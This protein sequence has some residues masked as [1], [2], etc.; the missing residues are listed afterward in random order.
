MS[1]LDKIK[2]DNALQS[3]AQVS[4]LSESEVAKIMTADERVRL[5]ETGRDVDA[6]LPM[7][8]QRPG[9]ARSLFSSALTG[10]APSRTPIV[11]G[12]IVEQSDGGAILRISGDDTDDITGY[13]DVARR[14][15]F[16]VQAGRTYQVSARFR[17]NVD[18]ANP[19]NNAVEVR[20]QNLAFDKSQINNVVLSG[21]LTPVFANGVWVVAYRIG[22]AG[23]ADNQH[24]TIPEAAR[25]GVPHLRIY[26]NGQELDVIDIDVTDI[27]DI[28]DAENE[29]AAQ[30]VN[31]RWTSTYDF[32]GSISAGARAFYVSREL[33][34][35]RGRFVLNGTYGTASTEIPTHHKLMLG[36]AMSQIY[37][38]LSDTTNPFRVA[39]FPALAPV[40]L[41][42]LHLYNVRSGAVS[43]VAGGEVRYASVTLEGKLTFRNAIVMTKNAAGTPVAMI[44]RCAYYDRQ[45]DFMS[46]DPVVLNNGQYYWEVPIIAASTQ[47]AR[48]YFDVVAAIAGQMPWKVAVASAVP[49][50]PRDHLLIEVLTYFNGVVKSPHMLAGE[51]P[52]GA[53]E[54]QFARGNDP[55]RAQIFS[56]NTTTVNVTDP[57]LTAMGLTRGWS[58]TDAFMGEE[59]PDGL[60]L[61][62]W[63]FGRV[64]VQASVDEGWQAPILYLLDRHDD[65]IGT[66][67]MVMEKRYSARV[68]SFVCFG[69][70]N[71][72]R[73]PKK[74]NIGTFQSTNQAIICGGQFYVGRSVNSV[75]PAM[76]YP[77][78]R[79]LTPIYGPQ[80]FFA[81]D[82]PKPV[83]L[84]NLFADRQRPAP[85][86]SFA[87]RKGLP[88]RPLDEQAS[89]G[90]IILDPA[91]IGTSVVLR[92][93]SEEERARY[94][95]RSVSAKV[96]SAALVG[97]SVSAMFFGDSISH[98]Q[99]PEFVRQILATYGITMT[100]LGTIE[101]ADTLFTTSAGGPKCE[102]REGW[103]T[104]D[105]LGTDLSDGDAANGVLPIGQ[106]TAYLAMSKEERR[107]YQVYLNPDI[108][109]GS[110]APIVT[111]GGVQY[112]FDFRFFLNRFGIADP[113]F[114][115]FNY[116]MNNLIE[117][118]T[119][120]LG[121]YKVDL[122]IMLAE[123]RRALPDTHII[124]WSTTIPYDLRVEDNYRQAWALMH[125]FLVEQ[126]VA[127]R[128]AGDTKMHLVSAWAHQ[129]NIAG[130]PLQAIATDAAGVDRCILSDPVHPNGEARDQ[131]SE[132]L[133]LAIACIKAGI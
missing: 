84:D 74:A 44:P 101:S 24:A 27:T 96:L 110:Q 104:T 103:A 102:A 20:W 116:G 15:D 82:R 41:R 3:G 6:L 75:I 42:Y 111:I 105:A 39:D 79:D 83:Y 123:L 35:K 127:L 87:S 97:A 128:A 54:S 66:A 52:G 26:G 17:R 130:W 22:K 62:G 12:T 10:S 106:E 114:L 98:R 1:H 77:G 9:D 36:S 56:I 65:T 46:F 63:Y 7:A 72:S 119:T 23:A 100:G 55:D 80:M 47:E 112:R 13:I 120:A 88:V 70:Y 51:V 99:T 14:I 117:G 95:N 60:P 11:A 71:Y 45:R 85:M 73:R 30:T 124:N 109:A 94:D 126:V 115:P 61:S 90:K 37:L 25:Y 93:I 8:P 91:R 81:W 49:T 31:L 19:A 92:R 43:R 16:P 133:A 48:V 33:Y 107:K 32:D 59:L 122:P 129:S 121:I 76:Q 113:E 50:F 86:V 18:A 68:A 108:N 5:E 53:V 40:G 131:H 89:G 64:L 38:D 34:A 125:R 78:S 132:E 28:L 4:A 58:G 118:R 29:L 67:S 21:T 69:R 2:V 57:I